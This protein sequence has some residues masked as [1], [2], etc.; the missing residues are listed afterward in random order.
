MFKQRFE[1]Q[2]HLDL[3]YVARQSGDVPQ[4]GPGEVVL[5]IVACGICGADVRVVKGDKEA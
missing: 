5:Q 3:V 2:R 4:S 1:V